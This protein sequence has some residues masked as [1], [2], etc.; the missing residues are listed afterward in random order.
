MQ[1]RTYLKQ[2]L[3][4]AVAVAIFLFI[5]LAYF[6][7]Q[8][9]GKVLHT[10]DGTVASSSSKE[11][12]DFRTKYGKE[13]LWTNSMFSGMPAYLI[14]IKYKNNLM[15]YADRVIKVIKLPAGSIFLTMVGFYV[16]LLFFKKF[17]Q[18]FIHNFIG[19]H[20]IIKSNLLITVTSSITKPF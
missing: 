4:H 20:N 16:L 7:P 5:S 11:V 19:I 13:A 18:Y 1:I 15:A 2:I 8:L 3:P 9:E 14:S 17:S 10:N 6:Y 12:N